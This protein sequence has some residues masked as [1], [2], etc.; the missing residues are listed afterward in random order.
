MGYTADDSMVRVDF[1]NLVG[2]G[3]A[4]K[5]LSGLEDIMVY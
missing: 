3:I 2:S 1:L 4:V 5:R